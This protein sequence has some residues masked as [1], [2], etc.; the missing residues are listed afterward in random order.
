MPSCVRGMTRMLCKGEILSDGRSGGRR[1]FEKRYS[2]KVNGLVKWNYYSN[3]IVNKKVKFAR[4]RE[5]QFI[6]RMK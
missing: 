2:L 4:N 3:D 5:E 6:L 1:P